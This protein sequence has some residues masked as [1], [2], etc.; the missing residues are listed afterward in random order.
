MSRIVLVSL[1]ELMFFGCCSKRKEPERRSLHASSDG[2]SVALEVID[3][4]LVV[5]NGS[6]WLCALAFAP[7]IGTAAGSPVDTLGVWVLVSGASPSGTT[8][9]R[10]T[11]PVA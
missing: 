3:S 4:Q 7:V 11:C 5:K 9:S 1:L 8:K 10:G 6:K 2:C